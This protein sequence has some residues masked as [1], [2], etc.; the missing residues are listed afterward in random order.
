VDVK[1]LLAEEIDFKSKLLILTQR[2]RWELDFRIRQDSQ[3]SNQ[4]L[5]EI[6]VFINDVKYGIGTASSKKEAEQI[7]SK[8]SLSLLNEI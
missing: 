5:Y 8:A 3:S 6:E 7:A 4:H 1:K 2:N